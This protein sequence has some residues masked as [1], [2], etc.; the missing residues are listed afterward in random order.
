MT[1][2]LGRTEVT[3]NIIDSTLGGILSRLSREVERIGKLPPE[4]SILEGQDIG[5]LAFF[6]GGM[7]ISNNFDALRRRYD[8][9]IKQDLLGQIGEGF[10]LKPKVRL[11][12]EPIRYFAK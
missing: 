3:N 12:N 6:S 5:K 1:E 7:V 10:Q 11:L 9:Y 4:L 8:T 2:T